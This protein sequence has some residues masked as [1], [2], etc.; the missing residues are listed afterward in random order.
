MKAALSAVLLLALSGC[1]STR[2]TLDPKQTRRDQPTYEDYFD[3]YWFGLS[4]KNSVD[5]QQVC[6]DQKPAEIREVKSV[7]DV[8]LTWITLGIYSPLTVQVWC[9]E[10]GS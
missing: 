7:D 3:Y 6:M 4:G 9:G 8:F 1:M 2:I 5:V 10:G